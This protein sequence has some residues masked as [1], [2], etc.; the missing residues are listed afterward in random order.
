MEFGALAGFFGALAVIFLAESFGRTVRSEHDLAELAP[1]AFLG[2]VKGG[3]FSR[4]GG[5]LSVPAGA[6]PDGTEA[7]QKV[8]S[9]LADANDGE[10]PHAVLV[11]GIQG[12]EGSALVAVRLA[13]A[14]AGPATRVI[15]AD[16][17]GSGELIRLLQRGRRTGA[18][19]LL[20]RDTPLHGGTAVLDRFPLRF[21]V[22]L[23]LAVPRSPLPRALDLDEARGL[24]E[25]L[26]GEA[27]AVVV[28]AAPPGRSPSTLGWARLADATVLVARCER[29]RRRNVAAA[30][31]GLEVIGA[32]AVGT[33]LQTARNV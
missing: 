9:R 4:N 30:L 19:P 18:T 10:P 17:G 31:E 32:N 16:F 22:P 29:T 28:H 6:S 2:S 25:L 33:V 20:G 7:Y 12:K 15:L 26:L 13:A 11:T 24:L 23:V 14:L 8:V 1:L 27:D 5:A 21:G 3:R